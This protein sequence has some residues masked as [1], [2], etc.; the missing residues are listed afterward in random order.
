MRNVKTAVSLQKSLFDQL[1]TLASQMKVS[2]SRLLAMALEEFI[3]HRE[4]QQLLEKINRA[5]DDAPDATEQMHLR[6]MRRLH[7]DIVEGDW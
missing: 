2:R 4:N 5:Y 6:K 3:R 7:R 1:E